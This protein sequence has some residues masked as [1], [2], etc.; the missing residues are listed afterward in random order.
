VRARVLL[1]DIASLQGDLEQAN[2]RYE[3]ALDATT[4]P[5]ERRRIENKRHRPNAVVREGA[6]IAFYE[7]GTGDETLLLMNPL[8]YGLTIFVRTGTVPPSPLP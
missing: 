8:V 2:R 3:Q 7:H 6:K 5:G 4:D 1:G